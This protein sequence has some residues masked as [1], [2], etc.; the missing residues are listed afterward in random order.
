MAIKADSL[1]R[2]V[3][4]L[5]FPEYVRLVPFLFLEGPLHGTARAG[6]EILNSTGGMGS[7]GPQTSISGHK[8]FLS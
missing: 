2:I 6:H 4:E 1:P 8:K 5:C 7:K 3:S